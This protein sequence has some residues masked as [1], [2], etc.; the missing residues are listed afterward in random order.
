MLHPQAIF[1]DSLSK[2]RNLKNVTDFG[3]SAR[4]GFFLA[5]SIAN[6]FLV[7]LFS[8]GPTGCKHNIRWLYLSH[9]LN[10]IEKDISFEMPIHRMKKARP[11]LHSS[12]MP[13]YCS[14]AVPI[15]KGIR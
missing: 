12:N 9:T 4:L 7:E 14:N 5:S 13:A 1:A 2:G 6:V 11:F 8:L 10:V 15:R 3:H